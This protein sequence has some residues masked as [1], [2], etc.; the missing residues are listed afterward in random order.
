MIKKEQERKGIRTKRRICETRKQRE[1]DEQ[2][3][4]SHPKV[5]RKRERK[6]Q[7]K[8]E[9]DKEIDKGRE[10]STDR[11]RNRERSIEMR[12]RPFSASFD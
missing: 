2:I 5:G 4:K 10:R 1:R 12:Y 7:R 9:N 8:G 11:Q 3:C 6:K